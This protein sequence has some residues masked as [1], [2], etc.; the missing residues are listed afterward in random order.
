MFTI[1]FILPRHIEK[2]GD[3][4]N[5]RCVILLSIVVLFTLSALSNASN[6][7][8]KDYPEEVWSHPSTGKVLSFSV[9]VVV[10]T[11]EGEYGKSTLATEWT[12]L[13]T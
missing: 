10:E 9:R 5:I 11:E 1:I 4:V 6:V 2:K 12:L 13:L 8:T 7:I 3:V